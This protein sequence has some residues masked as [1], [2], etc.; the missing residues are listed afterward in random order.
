M[1]RAKMTDSPQDLTYVGIGLFWVPSSLSAPA[2]LRNKSL[3]RKMQ[4]HD[5]V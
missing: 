1:T 5:T 3:P 2:S 4:L